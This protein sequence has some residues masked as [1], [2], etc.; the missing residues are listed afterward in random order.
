MVEGRVGSR[1]GGREGGVLA[2]QMCSSLDKRLRFLLLLSSFKMVDDSLQQKEPCQR[3]AQRTLA[4]ITRLS[5]PRSLAWL[6]LNSARPVYLTFTKSA[7]S[8]SFFFPFFKLSVRNVLLVETED[9]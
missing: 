9:R 5:L 4:R 2:L 8:S 3:N 7:P 6:P 1:E